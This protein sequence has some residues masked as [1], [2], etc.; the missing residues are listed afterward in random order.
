M[1]NDENLRAFVLALS[2]ENLLRRAGR[3]LS[4]AG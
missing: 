4:V 2:E 3:A 1:S